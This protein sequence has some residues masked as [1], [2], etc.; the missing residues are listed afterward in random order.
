MDPE[1][2]Y[3]TGFVPQGIGADLI[4]TL[5]GWSR[6]RRRRLRRGVAGPRREGVGQRLLRPL[7]R[8]GARPQ[9]HHRARHDELVRPGTTVES[10]AALPPAFAG[11]GDLGG[12]DAVALKKYHWVERDRPRAH[13]RQLLA[14]S[15]TA[16]R[17]SPVGSEEAGRAQRP[18]ARAPA[19]V[20]TAVVRRR[21]DDHAHRPG[22]GHPQGAGEGRPDRRRHRPGRDERGLRRGRHALHEGHRAS[23]TRRSTSTA[24]RSPWATR[25]ARPAP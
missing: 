5:A 2:A 14:A 18:D 13:R 7:R 22:A 24:A 1:T 19:S 4:A 20:G 8:P 15:S 23:T 17:W 11:I 12:F 9:R 21:P 3:A 16:P 10:L 25:W 6:D